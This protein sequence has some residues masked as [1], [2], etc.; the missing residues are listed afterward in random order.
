MANPMGIYDR[1]LNGVPSNAT[2][3]M[4][5]ETE[6]V[7]FKVY[8]NLWQPVLQEIMPR[9]TAPLVQGAI[10]SINDTWTLDTMVD[11]QT[12][13]KASDTGERTRPRDIGFGDEIYQARMFHEDGPQSDPWRFEHE[14]KSGFLSKRNQLLAQNAIRSISRRIEYE[15]TGYVQ[16]QQAFLDNY[17]D[18]YAKQITAGRQKIFDADEQVATEPDYLTGDR[19]DDVATVDVQ[20]IIQTINLY[21]SYKHE[22][23]TNAYIGSN[24]AY[25]MGKNPKLKE[26][27]KWHYDMTMTP[28]GLTVD[29]VLFKKIKGQTYKDHSVNS[30][31]VGYPGFGHMTADTFTNQ[32][33][34]RMMVDTGYSPSE[35]GGNISTEWAIF[36]SG[37]IGN[38]FTARTHPKHGDPNTPYAHSWKDPELEYMYS[39]LQ[40]AICPAVYDFSTFCVVKNFAKVKL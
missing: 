36:T 25:W 16:G 1:L 23:A 32:T 39:R 20:D 6:S 19:L 34:K 31:R 10:P 13:A 12:M 28:I 18:Q 40:L 17:G 38:I 5:R 33:L 8:D 35:G 9:T 27:K 14:L 29:Q 3:N 22:D 30:T 4:R 7:L 11:P 2:A 24:S 21:M 37:N 26:L 15:L